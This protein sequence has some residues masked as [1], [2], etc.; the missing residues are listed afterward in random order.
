MQ[1]RVKDSHANECTTSRKHG[2]SIRAAVNQ[3]R[4]PPASSGPKPWKR[5]LSRDCRSANVA[6]LLACRTEY[7]LQPDPESRP[8]LEGPACRPISRGARHHAVKKPSTGLEH[9]TEMHGQVM[10]ERQILPMRLWRSGTPAAPLSIRPSWGNTADTATVVS[11]SEA[12]TAGTG[13]HTPRPKAL[14]DFIVHGPL[15]EQ[16]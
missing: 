8:S 9:R 16:L 11:A 14:V 1:T 13:G 15:Q 2:S 10:A 7:R 12:E 3:S 6:R 4:L 5:A